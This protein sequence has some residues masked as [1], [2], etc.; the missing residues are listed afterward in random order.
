[1]VV[2]ATGGLPNNNSWHGGE[3]GGHGKFLQGHTHF[4]KFS[5]AHFQVYSTVAIILHILVTCI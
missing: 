5:Y 3:G 2:V 4:H 1:M